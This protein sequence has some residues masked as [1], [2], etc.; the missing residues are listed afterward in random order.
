MVVGIYKDC[1]VSEMQ[2]RRSVGRCSITADDDDDDHPRYN[3][4]GRRRRRRLRERR[5]HAPQ[6]LFFCV[7]LLFQEE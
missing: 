1:R 5:L 3:C 2:V 4:P 7:Q 6:F